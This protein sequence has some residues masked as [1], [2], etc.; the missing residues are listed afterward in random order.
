MDPRS[1]SED[2]SPYEPPDTED[3]LGEEDEGVGEDNEEDDM[4]MG[5]MGED[6]VA[7]GGDEDAYSGDQVDTADGAEELAEGHAM[8]MG[9]GNVGVGGDEVGDAAGHHAQFRHGG[10]MVGPGGMMGDATHGQ[11]MAVGGQMMHGGQGGE[12]MSMNSMGMHPGSMGMGGRG[13]PGPPHVHHPGMPGGV[14]VGP[15]GPMPG[16]GGG[17]HGAHGKGGA[18]GKRIK[19]MCRNLDDGLHESRAQQQEKQILEETLISHNMLLDET[20]NRLTQLELQLGTSRIPRINRAELGM[21]PAGMY[22]GPGVGH[23]VVPGGHHQM[24]PNGI[25]PHGMSQ[26]AHMGQH[27]HSSHSQPHPGGHMQQ[28]PPQHQ[29]GHQL[30]P[31]HPHAQLV[32]QHQA[33]LAAQKQAQAQGEGFAQA[34]MHGAYL[35]QAAQ[36]AH[37]QAIQRQM[38][39]QQQGEQ[40]KQG[41]P[42]LTQQPHEPQPHQHHDVSQVH[43]RSP[44]MPPAHQPQPGG[45]EHDSL[46]PQAHGADPSQDGHSGLQQQI[47]ETSKEIQSEQVSDQRVDSGGGGGEAHLQSD[48][49]ALKMEGVDQR[50]NQNI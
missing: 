31:D 2:S 9:V 14:V 4:G 8:M 21:L 5:E 44:H 23:Q 16:Q 25:G 22:G 7:D 50:V 33:Q 41:Q 46:P 11:V 15:G 39:I 29:Q 34:L 3:A 32:A 27:A 17:R 26:H 47:S 38:L 37:A 45:V 6:D 10:R 19:I 30:P 1:P 43:Q 18:M 48:I 12:A 28:G 42:H 40:D 36:A 49:G 20:R 24:G 13:L 35:Q